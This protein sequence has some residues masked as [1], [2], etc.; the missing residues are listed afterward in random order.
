MMVTVVEIKETM[1]LVPSLIGI[2]DPVDSIPP[3][4]ALLTFSFMKLNQD[5][6][7]FAAAVNVGKCIGLSSFATNFEFQCLTC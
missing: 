4:R 7:D 5:R 2:I 3:G 6:Q 1:S